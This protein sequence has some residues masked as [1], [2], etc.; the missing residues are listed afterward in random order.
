M[1]VSEIVR[2]K[3]SITAETSILLGR[4]LGVSPAFWLGIQMDH[5]LAL[6]ALALEKKAA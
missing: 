1:R 3:R 6:A 5:D 4:A 2:G